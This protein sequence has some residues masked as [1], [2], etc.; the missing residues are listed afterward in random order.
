M[1]IGMTFQRRKFV[2]LWGELSEYF[3]RGISSSIKDNFSE[4]HRKFILGT[5]RE[6]Q[7]CWQANRQTYECGGGGL[8]KLFYG[9]VYVVR[10]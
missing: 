10:S 5:G 8:L 1:L 7:F 4:K 6:F 9:C 3:L 2:D